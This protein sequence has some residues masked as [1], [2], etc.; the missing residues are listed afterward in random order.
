MLYQFMT[1]QTTVAMKQIAHNKKTTSPH[2]EQRNSLENLKIKHEFYNAGKN[3][4]SAILV[5]NNRHIHLNQ[6]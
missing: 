6:E 1:S 3:N 4:A 5:D 2:P